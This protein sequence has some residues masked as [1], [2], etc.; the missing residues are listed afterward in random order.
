MNDTGINGERNPMNIEMASPKSQ[1]LCAV[2]LVR[3]AT[4]GLALAAGL[5]GA[6]SPAGRAVA[7]EAPAPV[8][9]FPGAEGAGRAFLDAATEVKTVWVPYGA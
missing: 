9:A 1:H 6:I 2:P 8:L 3:S 5:F 4:I 7:Q